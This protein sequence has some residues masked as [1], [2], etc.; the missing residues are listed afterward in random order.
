[1]NMNMNILIKKTEL[2]SALLWVLLIVGGTGVSAASEVDKVDKLDQILI[3]AQK[4]LNIHKDHAATPIQ[5]LNEKEI[6]KK[7]HSNLNELV[8]SQ[9]GVDV[10]DYC[11]SCGAT[12]LSINGMRGE[13]TSILTDGIPLFSSIS[14]V[15]G[16]DSISTLS[17]QEIEV[18]RGSGSALIFPESIG[19]S[20]NLI[21]INPLQTGGRVGYQHSTH[22]NQAGE[23][24]YSLVHPGIKYTLGADFDRQNNWDED[25]NNIAEV[26]SRNRSS[27][28]AKIQKETVNLKW[29][30]RASY[31]TLSIMGGSTEEIRLRAPVTLVA[32]PSDFQDGDVRLPYQ[33][34]PNKIAEYIEVDRADLHTQLKYSVSDNAEIE[35]NLGTAYYAQDS[36]YSHAF[37]YSNQSS[38][39]YGDIKWNKVH[40]ENIFTTLGLSHRREY[41][42]SESE[43]MY[44]PPN[45]LPKD[46]FDFY[47]LAAFAQMDWHITETLEI[48]N[49][50]RVDQLSINRLYGDRLSKNV[51]APRMNIKYSPKESHT[52]Y[53]T[54]G[55]GYRMP[56][57][58]TE[59]A[60]GSYD[61]FIVETDDL[62]I[63]HS[64]LYMFSINEENYYFT[65]SLHYTLLKN[66]AYDYA[67]DIAHS[68]PVAFVNDPKDHHILVAEVLAGYKPNENWL[69][70]FSYETFQYDTDYKR[71]LPVAAIENRLGFK[72]SYQ[73]PKLRWDVTAS[74]VLPRN[75]KQYGSYD[76]YYNVYIDDIFVCSPACA[77][78]AKNT[79]APAFLYLQT[80]LTYMQ[81]QWEFTLGVNNILDETQVRKGD[82]PAMWHFHDGHAHFDNR[83]AWGLNRGR[84]G[85]LKV[86]YTF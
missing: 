47:S 44:T 66:M 70:E 6:R 72:S 71:K 24:V 5:V 7:N 16:V 8:D 46:D 3:R 54:Y 73:W 13:H 20:L 80:A 69:L 79:T 81:Q 35:T 62:E 23:F 38:I 10:Q 11:V 43:V 34:N 4:N 64:F 78:S 29:N 86:S 68:A 9:P 40:T 59:S 83:N 28:F 18:L 33:G 42:R 31:S 41:L 12:R 75:L 17:I 52:H 65:P 32:L 39:F 36:F 50:L 26:P 85:Y 77:R 30:T 53:L 48:S 84:E 57:S 37:D 58:F 49:A 14:S 51:L 74:Y 55:M 19:G 21:T 76:E 22:A 27:F 61:G 2:Y 15:Y 60:H 67:P 45:P 1:M 25:Q 82:S 56:L 63:S